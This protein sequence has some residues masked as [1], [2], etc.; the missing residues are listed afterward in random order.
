MGFVFL[1]M[2][3]YPDFDPWPF[4]FRYW[5]VILICV[6]LGKIWDSYYYRSHPE[7]TGGPWISGTGVAWIV[8]LALFAL[9]AW[10]RGPMWHR[11]DPWMGD[12]GWHGHRFGDD[13]HDTRTVEL[14]GAK[15]V[16]V[17]LRMP[18][19]TLSLSGG[20]GRLLD[21][22]FQYDR[23]R[24]KP[25]VEY[26]VSGDHGQLTVTQGEGEVHFGSEDTEWILRMGGDIPLD[27]NLNLG[28]GE[29]DMRLRGL[30]VTHLKVN[31]GAGELR[32]DL[33]GA[34]KSNLDA[35]IEGG[36]GEATI[37]L[38]K[39][40]GVRAIASGG[41]GGVNADG[42][43]HDGDAYVNSVYGKT[44]TE[45]ELTVHGGIGSINLVEE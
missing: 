16:S 28:A 43:T 12:W 10:H 29:S 39:D 7:Q 32:L 2:T 40:V 13:M 41:I 37:R 21:A 9:A 19:G 5:P 14:Q 42:L 23:F 24:G 3:L 25:D 1:G 34:R 8:L 35:D 26:A 20:S 31:M 38:P 15:S 17:D 22:N 4:L 33:T 30:N 44:P 18:A 36:V 6:G 45:I 27:L 11:G